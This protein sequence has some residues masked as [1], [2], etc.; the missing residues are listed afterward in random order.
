MVIPAGAMGTVKSVARVKAGQETWLQIDVDWDNRRQ[1]MLLVP[2]DRFVF[3]SGDRAPQ[4]QSKEIR[5][6]LEQ[7]ARASLSECRSSAG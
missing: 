1:L 7:L 5:F 2:P 4:E 6:L 3:L